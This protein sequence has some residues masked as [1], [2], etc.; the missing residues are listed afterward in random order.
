MNLNHSSI[1]IYP[2]VDLLNEAQHKGLICDNQHKQSITTLYMVFHCFIMLSAFLLSVIMLRVF[3]LSF[4]MLSVVMLNVVA[5][6]TDGIR[7]ESL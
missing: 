4:I 2:I 7:A 6:L 5:P 3:I 1:V